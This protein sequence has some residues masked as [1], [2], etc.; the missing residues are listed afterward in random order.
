MKSFHITGTCIPE[1]NYMADTSQKLEQIMHMV[2]RGEYFVINKFRQYGKTTMLNLIRR[3]LLASGE[4]LP[5]SISLAVYNEET[6]KSEDNY[7]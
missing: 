3:K 7:N 2:T 1:E 6:Y 5:I 4:Y